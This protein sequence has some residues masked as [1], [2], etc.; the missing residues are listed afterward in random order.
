[1]LRLQRIS[2]E[3]EDRF[4]ARV[5]GYL[6]GRSLLVTAPIINGKVQIIRDGQRFVVR[7]LHGSDVQGFISTVLRSAVQPYPYLH[8]SYPS[9]IESIVVRNAERV[10]TNLN[11]LVRNTADP[12][13]DMHWHP[14]R[15]KDLSI[16]GARLESVDNLGK[17]NEKLEL[18]FSIEVCDEMEQIRL[19]V[20]I[21]GSIPPDNPAAASARYSTGIQFELESR[22]QKLLLNNYVLCQK[23]QL[24]Y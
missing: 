6:T 17:V 4:N 19:V 14:V 18:K 22:Y 20:T 12:D 5:I 13:I 21:R 2:P 16:T 15:I 7:M 3:H 23:L 1:M 10:D 8:L 9:E 24:T 11:A